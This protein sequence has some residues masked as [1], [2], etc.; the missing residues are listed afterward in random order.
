MFEERIIKEL[1]TL[2]NVVIF[3]HYNKDIPAHFELD[4]RSLDF[5]IDTIIEDRPKTVAVVV[6]DRSRPTPTKELLLKVVPKLR[7]RG[8]NTYVV[9]ATGLHKIKAEDI[10]EIVADLNVDVFLNEPEVDD[11]YV[12]LGTTPGGIP[13]KLLDKVVNTDSL[14][15][16]CSVIP[17][18]W[19]GFTGGSKLLLPGT[20]ARDVIIEHH[21]RFFN[22]PN[23]SPGIVKDNPFRREIDYV[24]NL[25][26]GIVKVYAVNVVDY[27][28]SIYGTFGE[29]MESYTR[30]VEL[31]RNMYVREVGGK[32]DVLVVDGRPLNM[33]LYQ[34]VKAVF[35][36]L[37]ILSDGGLA[38]LVSSSL[39]ECPQEFVD[40]L[41]S[42]DLPLD[43]VVRKGV[44]D[45][46][47]YLV[48]YTLKEKLRGR[49]L[50]M[51]TNNSRISFSSE[52]LVIT[53]R[54][55]SVL[56]ELRSL[57][58]SGL[59]VC[60]VVEGAKYVHTSRSISY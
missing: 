37:G 8:L 40:A 36:N 49:R 29:L 34:S 57:R 53:N 22:H 9:V 43:E 50:V 46:V 17:H 54:Y 44:G 24:G 47:P 4:S 2:K 60:V 32:C 26:S 19:A 15:L 56:E 13:I 48:A 18:V 39:G 51:L 7:G 38:I 11:R 1:T 35:N 27:N 55:D 59:R 3:N 25:I 41:R 30:A 42:E 23:A 10:P 45:V 31:S 28:A 14:L 16:I 52:S 21:L 20:S 58:V 33:N 6:T 5:L 12:Y